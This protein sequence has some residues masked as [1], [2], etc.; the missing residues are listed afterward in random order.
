MSG[1]RNQVRDEH[2]SAHR[3]RLAW[4]RL[5]PGFTPG[6]VPGAFPVCLSGI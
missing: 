2:L 4:L 5:W 1:V 3:T 6:G